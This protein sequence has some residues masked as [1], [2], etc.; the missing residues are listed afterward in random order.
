MDIY[1]VL[2]GNIPH[3]VQMTPEEAE[4]IGAKPVKQA[5]AKSKAPLNKSRNGRNKASVDSSDSDSN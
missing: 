3:Q 2:I 1:E 4:K 5:Q